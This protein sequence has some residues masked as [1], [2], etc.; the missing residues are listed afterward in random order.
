[1]GNS[2]ILIDRTEDIYSKCDKYASPAFS[3]FLDEAQRSQ[4]EDYF[5]V[6]A[7]YNV[8][9]F[10]GCDAC[11]RRIFGVFPEWYEA[12]KADFP[13]SC[14]KAEHR[15]G[16]Q[17]THRQYLGSLLGLGID[18]SKTGDIFIS[19]NT[20]Y[21]FL[22]TDIAQYVTANFSRVGSVAVKVSE[23][24]P[25]DAVIPEREFKIIETA[26][27]S[28]RA[29]A[30]IAAALGVS[31]S[32]SAGLIANGSISVNHRAFDN[33]SKPLR[34]NDL[35]SARGYG[36]YRITG[37]GANTRSGRIHITVKKYI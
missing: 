21:I 37:F 34:E 1:M 31:R 23:C 13:I 7:G 36:R 33:P 14:I 30:V 29:D 28:E 3:S 22:C 18:R 10:G 26:A 2:D 25:E 12:E 20:A 15:F 4:I 6:R 27:A 11:E 35:I 32:V 8:M 24:A 17:L 19:G 5:G 16:G 9:F